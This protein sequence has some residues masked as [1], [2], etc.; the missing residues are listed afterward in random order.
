M[1]S[2]PILLGASIGLFVFWWY[3]RQGAG[4]L[5]TI[6]INQTPAQL[7]IY[8]SLFPT[9]DKNGNIVNP[10]NENFINPYQG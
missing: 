7:A 6:P 8:H 2:N 10:V 4:A 1:K 9:V 5:A 3:N